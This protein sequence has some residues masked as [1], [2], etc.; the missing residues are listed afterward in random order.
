MGTP[1]SELLLG[2]R[3]F[4]NRVHESAAKAFDSV[5]IVTRQ[6]VTTPP[7]TR[8]LFDRPHA[9]SSSIHGLLR[10]LE[11]SSDDKLWLLAVDFPLITDEI[12]RFLAASFSASDGEFLVPMWHGK[13]QM[14]CAGYSR[15]LLDVVRQKIDAGEHRMQSVIEGRRGD[16]LAEEHLREQF[17]D[18]P[19]WN[20]NQPEEYAEVRRRYE[21]A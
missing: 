2:G 16:F 21:R 18:E 19:L 17:D 1:K 20:V 11:A 9:G 7:G 8:V 4:F 13:P 14:L 10:A 12:L 15:A 3:S 6:S 5:V